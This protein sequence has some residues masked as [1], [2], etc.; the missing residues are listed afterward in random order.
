MA[1][2]KS[3][4]EAIQYVLKMAKEQ[5]LALNPQKISGACGRLMCCLA[6]EGEDGQGAGPAVEPDENILATKMGEVKKTPVDNFTA[7]RSSGLIA[8]DLETA[9][10]LVSVCLATDKDDVLMVTG[11]DMHGTPITIKLSRR[12]KP[13]KRLLSFTMSSS[14]R[15]SGN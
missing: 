15:L 2:K 8:M 5:N 4:E 13:L 11:S 14:P 10:E 9:D 12:V 1:D 6:Y 7:V 3:R